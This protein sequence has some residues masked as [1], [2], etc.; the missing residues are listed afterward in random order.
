[1]TFPPDRR[2]LRR[3]LDGL[4]LFRDVFDDSIGRAVRA[5]AEEASNLNAARLVALLMEEAE[6][7]PDE[8]VGDAWQN[9]VLDR[10]LV[11]DNVFSRKAERAGLA[12]MGEGLVGE[13]RRELGVLQGLFRDGGAVLASEAFGAL[14]VVSSP[15]W[16]GLRPL[17]GGPPIHGPEARA[18]KRTLAASQDWPAEVAQLAACYAANGVGIFG[19]FRAFRWVHQGN[20]G[21]LEGVA[22]PDPVRLSDLVGYEREREPVVQNAA[23][24]A[25]G[26][27]GNNALLYGERGT[28]KSSTVKALLSEYGD[29]GLRLIEV[30]KE[31]LDDFHELMAPLRDRSERFILYVDDLSFEEQ[32]THYKALKAILEGG[33][34]ARPDNVVLY[35]T[36]NRRHLVRERFSDRTAALEDD[37]HMMDT[38]EEKLSLSDRFGVRVTFGSP[39]QDRYLEI[40]RALASRRGII[41]P[42]TQLQERALSWAQ[43]QN[44]RSGRTARQF[45]DAL[46]AELGEAPTRPLASAASPEVVS[47][48]AGNGVLSAEPGAS[49]G[50][51]YVGGVVKQ[52]EDA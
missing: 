37:V 27:P 47:P 7:Y 46:V 2:N 34:E 11:A 18:M 43:R 24:F 22:N 28:G 23:R 6:L 42:D 36:S 12:A 38:L 3:S 39:D 51:P 40:V 33:I 8:A 25:A 4:A 19:R 5:L 52:P 13:A 9:H 20:K 14:G 45:I 16:R 26:L 48:G 21:Q 31:H 35:A 17:G 50:G 49:V 32:E 1:M 30:P 10:I 15:G 44:G 29:R 41:L